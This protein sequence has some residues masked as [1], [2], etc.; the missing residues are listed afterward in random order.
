MTKQL[1][2][3]KALL[4]SDLNLRPAQWTDVNAVAQLILDVCTHEGDPTVAQSPETV[5]E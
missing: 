3:N 1:Q 5:R 2:T 4:S